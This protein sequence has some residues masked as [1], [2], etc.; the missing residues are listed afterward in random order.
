MPNQKDSDLTA[1]TLYTYQNLDLDDLLGMVASFALLLSP[2]F[3]I[4]YV[5]VLDSSVD[6]CAAVVVDGVP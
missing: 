1:Y 5:V 3:C 6:E 2:Y 4:P